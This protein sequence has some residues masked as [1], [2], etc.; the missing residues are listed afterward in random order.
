VHKV[1][2]AGTFA[3]NSELAAFLHAFYP[4]VRIEREV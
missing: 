1:V 2:L 4:R 3:R